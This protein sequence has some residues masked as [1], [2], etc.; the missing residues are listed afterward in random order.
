MAICRLT[1][2]VKPSDLIFDV[3]Y[4]LW[5]KSINVL[6]NKYSFADSDPLRVCE[7]VN[8][9][10]FTYMSTNNR[11]ADDSEEFVE[12]CA[13]DILPLTTSF[14]ERLRRA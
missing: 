10:I 9:Y 13:Q 3:R 14:L 6:G 12:F 7:T 8:Y 1:Q 11:G 2:Y 5:R 4:G